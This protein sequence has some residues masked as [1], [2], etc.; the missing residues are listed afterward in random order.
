MGLHRHGL[1]WVF[2]HLYLTTKYPNRLKVLQTQF[3]YFTL[4]PVIHPRVGV[5]HS[6][7]LSCPGGCAHPALAASGSSPVL[8][9]TLAHP[10]PLSVIHPLQTPARVT[11]L[12]PARQHQHGPCSIPCRHQAPCVTTMVAQYHGSPLLTRVYIYVHFFNYLHFFYAI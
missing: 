8:H 7:L 12:L 4:T 5:P 1:P 2:T 3:K 11:P 6:V 9:P 10:A